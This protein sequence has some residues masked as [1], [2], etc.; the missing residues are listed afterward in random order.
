M[1][2]DFQ[3]IKSC[4][5]LLRYARPI[6]PSLTPSP[7]C[8]Q[9]GIYADPEDCTKFYMCSPCGPL[10]FYCPAGDLF[11]PEKKA[12]SRDEDKKCDPRSLVPSS[13][14]VITPE[15]DITFVPNNFSCMIIIAV[16][17]DTMED[18]SSENKYM[19]ISDSFDIP[20]NID[21][22]SSGD[23]ADQSN[24]PNLTKY[25]TYELDEHQFSRNASTETLDIGSQAIISENK[26]VLSTTR[27]EYTTTGTSIRPEILKQY[28]EEIFFRSTLDKNVQPGG[29]AQNKSEN[30][31]LPLKGT[32]YITS[33]D[34]AS[35]FISCELDNSKNTT[36]AI[37]NNS[38]RY[39]TNSTSIGETDMN[40][41]I[42]YSDSNGRINRAKFKDIS[43]SFNFVND[44]NGTLNVFLDN[45]VN[46]KKEAFSEY[47]GLGSKSMEEKTINFTI[48]HNVSNETINVDNSDL[49]DTFDIIQVGITRR[50]TLI[51][52]VGSESN[53]STVLGNIMPTIL[54]EDKILVEEPKININVSNTS[55]TEMSKIYTALFR[56]NTNIDNGSAST[57]KELV[58]EILRD[59]DVLE[60]TVQDQVNISNIQTTQSN[61]RNA[62]FNTV[63][64]TSTPIPRFSASPGISDLVR[65]LLD[66]VG[67][68]Q[69]LINDNLSEMKQ[70]VPSH[71]DTKNGTIAVGGIVAEH[72]YSSSYIHKYNKISH[73]VVL[74]CCLYNIIIQ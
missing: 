12:C 8:K 41:S 1:R 67:D 23:P 24:K 28:T 68:Y 45:N 59:I 54:E 9:N 31:S 20:Y 72:L 62:N 63:Q 15:V 53:N 44:D 2:A 7:S 25:N 5:D 3:G 69:D 65:D 52:E 51:N 16:E 48:N 29:I 50:T 40:A 55:I 42:V 30:I 60:G 33:N 34:T 74:I 14:D 39:I 38:A 18:V 19:S 73:Y 17:D 58:D 47:S 22:K 11:D 32:E 35:I 13:Q 27:K 21:S 70:S 61:D 6:E 36:E 43:K 71:D 46:L 56:N 66:H 57:P 64:T 49:E 4:F 37:T 26:P 10:Q